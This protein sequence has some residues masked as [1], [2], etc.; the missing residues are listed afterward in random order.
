MKKVD[1]ICDKT[2]EMA[3]KAET[4]FNAGYEK[5]KESETFAKISGL[6]DQVGDYVDQ[7]ITEFKE[8][9]IPEK[10]ENLR[11]KAEEKTE[12][13]V[14]QVKAFGA[15]LANDVEEVIGTV[16]EKLAG[17]KEKK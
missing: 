15:I 6:V 5:V 16:K 11:D 17:D 14:D 13:V 7:K 8:S 2:K 4:A 12:S 9:D 1:E 10:L 3:D